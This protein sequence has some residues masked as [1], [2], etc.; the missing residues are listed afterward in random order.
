M[1]KPLTAFHGDRHKIFPQ[2][3]VK[4]LDHLW[5][6]S[7]CQGPQEN[8]TR[9]SN[10]GPA[11]VAGADLARSEYKN[12]PRASHKSCHASTYKT[13]HL[14][15]FM[16]GPQD[17]LFRTWTGSCKGLLGRNF[18]G[19]PQEPVHARISQENAAD[20]ELENPAAHTSREPARSKCKW[21]SHKNH[22]CKNA[23]EKC[24]A[25]GARQPLCASERGRNAA[26]GLCARI[27]LRE[28]TGKI[29][30]PRRATA[31]WRKPAQSKCN[32]MND[33]KCIYK[34]SHKNHFMREFTGK[35]RALTRATTTLRKPAQ[36]KCTWKS[37]K[38]HFMRK[39]AGK[40]RRP[41]RATTTLC[42]SAQAKCTW[43]F[44]QESSWEDLQEKCRAPELRQSRGA[45]H[46]IMF[47]A[48]YHF[49]ILFRNYTKLALRMP[50]NRNNLRHGICN[51][52]K[53]KKSH[54]AVHTIATLEL[55][56]RLCML[57]FA[58]YV[59]PSLLASFLNCYL[60][61]GI[62]LSTFWTWNL[63]FDMVHAA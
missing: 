7:A 62:V 39:F 11:A 6:R 14:Q 18:A 23:Q 46:V 52:L 43:T 10:K 16:Q 51:I 13:W 19:S 41:S 45:E 56:L 30:R 47:D 50:G 44:A 59:F 26:H 54:F 34:T 1:Q 21:K 32:K 22:L 20:Q 31:T 28:F 63:S 40:K 36:S 8:L 61:F 29:P 55:E 57:W 37:H 15:I 38:S 48:Q 49:M 42:E 3:L 24:R 33:V 58:W 9:S 35:Y 60:S 5:Q 25:P 53:L 12:L 4:D 27:L 2:G 17:L